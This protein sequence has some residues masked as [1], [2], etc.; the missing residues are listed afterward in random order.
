M[1]SILANFFNHVPC[2]HKNVRVLFGI[3]KFTSGKNEIK[4]LATISMVAM[5]P[6]NA[7]VGAQPALYGLVATIVYCLLFVCGRILFEAFCG[8]TDRHDDRSYAA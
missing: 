8:L 2:E 7:V 3:Q 1:R 6:H 5:L 4:T